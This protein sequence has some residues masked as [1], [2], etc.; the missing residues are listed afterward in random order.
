M[1]IQAV[2]R[3]RVCGRDKNIVGN[4]NTNQFLNGS[5]ETSHSILGRKGNVF[6]LGCN[7]G[8]FNYEQIW[9]AISLIKQNYFCSLG[10][11]IQFWKY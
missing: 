11:I 9:V 1:D 4:S 10:M 7:I 6:G 2:E 5:N 8:T 3:H